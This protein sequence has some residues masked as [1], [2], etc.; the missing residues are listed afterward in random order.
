MTSLAIASAVV[1][2]GAGLVAAWY[3]FKSSKVNIAP[4]GPDWGLPG[5]GSPIEPVTTEARLLDVAASSIRD[6]QKILQAFKEG[7]RLSSVAAIWTAV[8]VAASA[9]S[10]ILGAFV[11]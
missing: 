1:A 5:T 10:A 3:W 6:D 9:T 8:S 4:L 7:A 2:C 11:N